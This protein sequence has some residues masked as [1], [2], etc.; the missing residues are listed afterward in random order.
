MKIQ[1]E[2]L[3]DLFA[4]SFGFWILFGL[5]KAFKVQKF[6]VAR[7]QNGTD[8]LSTIFFREH[9]TFT[10][11]LPDFFSSAIYTAHLLMCVWGWDI[12]GKKKAFRDIEN[13]RKIIEHF[14]VKEIREVKFFAIC[15]IIAS[16]HLIAFFLLR[17]YFP[18]YFT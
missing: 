17:L 1:P 5:Y 11:Q 14:S 13:H 18:K 15:G 6:I 16:A 8:L 9:A 3:V 7:Y 4:I 2:V 12:Y 10:R